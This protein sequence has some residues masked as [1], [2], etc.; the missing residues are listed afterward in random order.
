MQFLRYHFDR[1]R[2]Q[3]PLN[4]ISEFYYNIRISL[5]TT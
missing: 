4:F 2:Q 3:Q 1:Q 5:F